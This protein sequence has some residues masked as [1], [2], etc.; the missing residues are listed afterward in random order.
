[1]PSLRTRESSWVSTCQGHVHRHSLDPT[2]PATTSAR[3]EGTVPNG[4]SLLDESELC[5][6]E[7]VEPHDLST[8]RLKQHKAAMVVSSL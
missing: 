2:S 7:S 1:M 3:E 8:T 6:P 5:D 4:D